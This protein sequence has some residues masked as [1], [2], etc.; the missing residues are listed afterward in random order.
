MK[1]LNNKI[2]FSNIMGVCISILKHNYIYHILNLIIWLFLSV[3]PIISGYIIKNLFDSL[4]FTGYKSYYSNLILLSLLLLANIFFTYQ[5]GIYDAKSRFYIGKFLRSNLFNYFTSVLTTFNNSSLL[6]MFNTDIALNRPMK[7]SILVFYL[8][9]LS[10]YLKAGISLI[11]SVRILERQS[12]KSNQRRIFSNIGYELVKGES[13]SNA[14]AAQGSVFPK[15]FINMTKTAEMTGDLPSVLDDMAEYYTTIDKTRKQ[16]VSAMAYPTIIFVFSI[17][18]IT[19]ILTYVIPTFT[20]MFSSNNATLPKITTTVIA[21]SDFLRTKGLILIGVIIA[22]L[23]IYTLAFKF[24]KPFRKAMQSFYMR[25]PVV[26]N[27]VIY[28][29]VSMFTKTFASLLNHDVF[30]TDTMEILS[31]ITTNEVYSDIIKESLDNLAKGARISDAFKGKWAFPIV[32]YEMLVT[33]ENTGKLPTMMNHVAA[34]YEDLYANYVKRLNTFIEPVM[35]IFLAA[36]VGVVI[37][38]VI[39][40]M[41]SF[42]SQVL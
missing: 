42:N 26:K 31:N 13:F 34:Y 35:I 39:I 33:G 20:Q 38:S 24:I 2:T 32:A 21:I 10:T 11:D 41:L 8:T 36:I 3:L 4:N 40:P 7:K 25:L 16:T 9:Q 5:G 18:V 17:A 12:V 6:N 15:L 30:I 27:L 1:K 22:V 37:L 28:R 14:L 23:L 29:E 19:F